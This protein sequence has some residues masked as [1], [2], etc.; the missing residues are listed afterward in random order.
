MK[1]GYH[2]TLAFT[3][4]E[5][6]VAITI[7]SIIFLWVLNLVWD[8]LHG[9]WTSNQSSK[10]I[11]SLSEVIYKF[12]ELNSS[13]TK[14]S[15]FIGKDQ[16]KGT[17]ILLLSNSWASS[18]GVIIA[19]IDPRSKRVYNSATSYPL[20]NQKYIW[21]RTLDSTELATINWDSAEVYKLGFYP[22]KIFS[23][24]YLK[25]FQIEL[26]N[27][28]TIADIQM[29]LLLQYWKEKEGIWWE[30]IWSDQLFNVNLNF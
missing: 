28:G 29:S 12:E 25:D 14:K 30:D 9:L 20:Y 3:L 23:D 11:V 2:Q 17:D 4:V 1:K 7:S 18:W 10:L 21:Y 19:L 26:Y 15:L 16:G 22:D 27:S 6:V 24:I 5:L 13:Y 8:T